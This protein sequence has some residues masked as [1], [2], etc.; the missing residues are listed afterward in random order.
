MTLALTMG[1]TIGLKQTMKMM[2]GELTGVLIIASTAVIGG[3]TL[4]SKYP[5]EYNS[6]N[7]RC[8]ETLKNK[9]ECKVGYSGHERSGFLIS[10]VAAAMGATSIERHITLDRTIYGS[11][12]AASLEPE[13]FKKMVDMVKMVVSS[14]GDGIKDLSLIHI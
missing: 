7:L 11:D 14:L 3:G 2:A 10:C 9:Y 12:Q 13:G 5:F 8:I 4:I 1:M 6:A